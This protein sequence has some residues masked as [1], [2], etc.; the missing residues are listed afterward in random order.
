MPSGACHQQQRAKRDKD[1]NDAHYNVNENIGKNDVESISNILSKW[2]PRLVTSAEILQVGLFY[3]GFDHDRQNKNNLRRKTEWFK[4]FYG[5]EPTTVAAL[6]SSIKM[7]NEHQ[8]VYK[9]CLLTL[10]W[11]YLYESYP[12]LSG[13]WKYC[14]EY[15]AKTVM[16]YGFMMA[17]VAKKKLS[18]S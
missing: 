12:V 16:I 2:T 17:R 11:L 6:F 13:R 9:D 15:I 1:K 14:Q 3:A 7:E 18:L 10:N 5:V 4:S 8:F